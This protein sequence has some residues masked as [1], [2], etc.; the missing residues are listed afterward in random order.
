MTHW[1]ALDWGTSQLRAWRMGQDGTL[2]DHRTSDRGMGS[3]TPDAFEPALLDLINDWLPSD[4]ITPVIACGMVGA[5]QGWC[6]VP[7]APVPCVPSQGSTRIAPTLDPR[8][9][10]TILSGLCQTTPSADVMRGEETQIAGYLAQHPKFD[11]VICLP[12]THTKWAHISAEEV[13]SFQTFMTG[14]LFSLL[15]KYSVLRHSIAEQGWQ[16]DAFSAA[17]DDAL[18]RPAA[19]AARLFGLRAADIL[20]GQDPAILRSQLSGFL[21]GLELSG[22]RP[23]WLGQDIVLIG[24]PGLCELYATAL[25]AQGATVVIEDATPMTLAGLTAVYETCKGQTA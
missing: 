11:G 15:S 9:K 3:L 23:Y 1:I 24:E 4:A 16:Q 19:I 6:E 17:I 12:G 7:Y 2:H 10:V 13:V 18:S 5:K 8:H 21:I 22:A 14:E 20:Q 25:N